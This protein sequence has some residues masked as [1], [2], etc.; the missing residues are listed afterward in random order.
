MPENGEIN[1]ENFL[2]SHLKVIIFI[3]IYILASAIAFYYLHKAVSG[4]VCNCTVS[5]TW[6]VALMSA[7]GV[8]VG[9]GVYIYMK[10]TLIPETA[11][12]K[13][14]QETVRFLPED[15]R[16]II[17]TLIS[18]EGKISQSRLPEKT[19]LSKVKISRKLKE[20]ER[21]GIVK[22]EKSGMTNTVYLQEKFQKILI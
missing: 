22:K 10:N 13:E 1:V 14:I 2:H 12:N 9:I 18:S 19:D 7:T 5:L 11:S 3:L 8:V 4:S 16:K 6:I 17:E 15:Q 20:L 21:K